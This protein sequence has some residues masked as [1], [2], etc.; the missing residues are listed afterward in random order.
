MD[1]TAD[2]DR[3]NNW[4]LSTEQLAAIDRTTGRDRP[5]NWPLSTKQPVAI[6]QT[7]G[8]YRPNNWPR[9][10][11]QLAAIDQTTGRYR[12]NNWPPLSDHVCC[13]HHYHYLEHH[14]NATTYIKLQYYVTS[15]RDSS[16]SIA[17]GYG[18]DGPGIESPGGTRF[19]AP[20]QTDPVAHQASY[21]IGT[22]SFS[23]V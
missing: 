14:Y 1:Q 9:S 2:H 15:D 13:T 18:M 5:N 22:G 16:V 17:I 12:P 23:G 6:D 10:T 11:K 4:P 20:V 19:S 21:T 7:T 8:R 3:P